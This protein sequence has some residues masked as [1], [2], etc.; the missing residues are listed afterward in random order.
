MPEPTT[1]EENLYDASKENPPVDI[2]I[3]A[4]EVKE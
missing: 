2:I 4:L 3:K 1:H